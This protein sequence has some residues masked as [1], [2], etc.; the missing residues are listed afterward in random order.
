[1]HLL[2]VLDLGVLLVALFGIVAGKEV[3]G[4]RSGI[5]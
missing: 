3:G 4:D 1:M 5:K 2:D